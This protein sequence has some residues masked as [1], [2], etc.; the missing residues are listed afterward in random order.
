M[1]SIS[2][3]AV[4][5]I[6]ALV[7]LLIVLYVFAGHRRVRD[8]NRPH[9]TSQ[10]SMD[11][12]RLE[13]FRRAAAVRGM[14]DSTMAQVR[15][16]SVVRAASRL[17]RRLRSGSGKVTCIGSIAVDL[18]PGLAVA[19]TRPSL[20]AKVSYDLAPALAPGQPPRLLLLRG[21]NAIVMPLATVSRASA[22]NQPV[23][24]AAPAETVGPESAPATVGTSTRSEG[25][26]ATG[27]AR[28]PDHIRISERSRRPPTSPHLVA[29]K[30]EGSAA[31][32][33]PASPRRAEPS[34][35][36]A[37]PP[38]RPTPI[39][40]PSF[41]CRYARSRGEIAVCSDPLLASLDR[42][43]ST[44]FFDALS[45]AR[46]GQRAMLQRT[47]NRFLRYR[48]SCRSESC[49][50]DAYRARMREIS[51]IMGGAW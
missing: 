21:A 12:V 6:A 50:A 34:E 30:R 1:R 44:Q 45:I 25:G 36:V 4:V 35:P 31:V 47:R 2:T 23:L 37:T 42:Q 51:W 46:P 9:C 8:A 24:E 20:T 32:V 10:Q 27:A 7:G 14:N 17:V 43:M 5:F 26:P 16:Y 40:R 33:P 39:A 18:P 11:V 22:T 28:P 48:D 41:N 15:D 29:P 49:I 13:L 19:G 3:A 38:A